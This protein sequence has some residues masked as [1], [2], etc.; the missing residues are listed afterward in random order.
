MP[1]TV[2]DSMWTLQRT[3]KMALDPCTH[4]VQ[5]EEMSHVEA[6]TSQTE[7]DA[8]MCQQFQNKI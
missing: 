5:W 6:D 3:E 8:M 2:L 1:D 7:N 4:G